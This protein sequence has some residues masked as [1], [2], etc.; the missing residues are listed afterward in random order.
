M[1]LI[2]FTPQRII[3]ATTIENDTLIQDEL[4]SILFLREIPVRIEFWS[5]SKI[6]N[7]LFLYPPVVQKYFPFRQQQVE[8]ARIA[9]LNKSVYR[10]S[11]ENDWL[12]NYQNSKGRSHLPVFDFTFIN[13]TDNTVTLNAVEGFMVPQAVVRG[14]FPPTPS[15]IV[16]PTGKYVIDLKSGLAFGEYG[17]AVLDFEDPVYA[18][19]K[20]AFR[21]QIQNRKPI[22]NFYKIY[23]VFNFNNATIKT[24]ELY[25][26]AYNTF[27]GVLHREI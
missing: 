15:G 7:A 10:K 27:S 16:K 5:W 24:P 9:V 3:I 25:F 13:N 18:H 12:F 2:F 14:G 4:Q 23:F 6:S 17:R 8:L 21:I 20:A 11:S 1:E 19:P 22:L 26:N